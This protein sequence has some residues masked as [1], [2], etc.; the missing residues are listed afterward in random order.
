[1]TNKELGILGETTAI[2]FGTMFAIVFYVW[3]LIPLLF[4]LV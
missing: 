4:N 1:M 2:M 3:F